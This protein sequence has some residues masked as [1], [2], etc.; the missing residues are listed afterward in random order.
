MN[1]RF[2][3]VGLAGF[4]LLFSLS[5]FGVST[6]TL[7]DFSFE[8][9][10]KYRLSNV[11]VSEAG[12][13]RLSRKAAVLAENS[14]TLWA[15]AV[16]KPGE[17]YFSAGKPGVLMEYA[18]GKV[19]EVYRDTNLFLFSDIEL[20]GDKIYLCGMPKASLTIL[21]GR[22]GVLKTISLSNEYL[23]DM[24]PDGEGYYLLAGNPAELYYFNRKD[25]M[26]WKTPLPMED[27]LLKGRK[28]GQD[29]YF[30]GEGQSLYRARG[31]KVTAVAYFD[32]PVSDWDYDGGVFYVVTSIREVVKP[33][34]NQAR[35][36][37]Q[38]RSSQQRTDRSALYRVSSQG[39]SE[40]LFEKTGVKFLSVAKRNGRL[41]IGTD[42]DGGYFE[43][44]LF[45]QNRSFASMGDGKFVR[46][47]DDHS[48]LYAVMLD[49][50]R[51][52]RI[53]DAPAARGYFQ[54]QT[55]DAASVSLWGRPELESSGKV[56][57]EARFGAV[58]DDRLWSDWLKVDTNRGFSAVLSSS[59]QVEGGGVR[60]I[61][62]RVTLSAEAKK[63]PVFSG[64]SWPYTPFNGSPSI[65]KLNL[66][67]S[68]T[69]VKISW[70]AADPDHD[71]LIYRV[72]L[73]TEAGK[74]IPL[75]DKPQE[76]ASIDLYTDRIP[77]GR[78]RFQ[79]EASDER[80]NLPEQAA[81]ALK[82]T[83]WFTFD[84]TP[85]EIGGLKL[86]PASGETLL[87]FTA[88]DVLTE[89][90]E[91]S[92]SVNGGNWIRIN[93]LDAVYDSRTEEFKV[94]LKDLPS[95]VIQVRVRD[96]AGN[97]RVNGLKLP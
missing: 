95:G 92:Y 50:S 38:N 76:E 33:Q 36:D 26:V 94:R 49:P 53:E 63:S 31:G 84:S 16:K 43:T 7:R 66:S 40:L 39:F 51:I 71:T 86:V 20:S 37:E 12:E 4:F 24:V 60:M 75:I 89:I 48:G 97:S 10:E 5:A 52:V 65:G 23:W 77:D 21:D 2:W 35:P 91:A 42:K 82:I 72:F 59:G 81:R 67:E 56:D 29:F 34:Q 62:Y 64:I 74:K 19:R 44:D 9:V 93:P 30:S 83:D 45:G 1:R 55:F 17:F 11:S 85:P 87:A 70:D 73:E 32:G 3:P 61:Q 6:K 80:S 78:Y 69:M 13:V 27:N 28:V 90:V 54:S 15:L 46:F 18:S 79:I 8:T 41:I 58:Y 22:G 96:A 57:L 88:T 14:G 68:G 25:E 47:I